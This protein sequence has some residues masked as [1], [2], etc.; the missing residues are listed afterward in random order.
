MSEDFN[1]ALSNSAS[2]KKN[3]FPFRGALIGLDYGTK[4]M[5]IAVCN[6]D[7]TV[8]V[9][10]ETWNVRSTDQ[11]L[12]HLRHLIVEYRG[13]GFVVGLPVRLNGVEGA[14]SVLVRKFGDWL[15]KQTNIPVAYWD[16]RHS[17]NEAEVL[18]WSQGISPEKAKDRLDRLAAQ[19]IL[20]SFL[21]APDR[22]LVPQP[23][24]K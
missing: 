23:L 24:E 12:K 4:R 9:G 22:T 20:Q 2:V 8:A 17:S 13:V 1:T 15:S 11:N 3:G 18:L 21:D 7:Q 5:G 14:Q 19:I 6:F 10:V 16:E